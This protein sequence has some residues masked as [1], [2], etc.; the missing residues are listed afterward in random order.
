MGRARELW[1]AL[2]A[3]MERQDVDTVLDLYAPDAVWLE[4]QNPPH[5]TNRLIQAYLSDWLK[6]RDNV[7]VTTK[8]LLE[9]GDGTLLA[10]EWTISYDA[11]GRRWSDLPRS[12]WIECDED[13]I[14]YH[15]DYF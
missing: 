11:V 13:V 10:A 1:E 5:E 2:G 14:R 3:A 7:E 15:R 12:T 8:R 6:A 4:P 9:S